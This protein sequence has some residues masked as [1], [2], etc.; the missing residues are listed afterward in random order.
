MSSIATGLLA[1]GC[2]FGAGLLGMLLQAV[3]PKH[4]LSP[5]TKDLVRL[6]MGLVSTMTALVLGLLVAS[7]KGAYDAQRTGVSEMAAKVAFLDRLLA[8]YGTETTEARA[9]LRDAVGVALARVWPEKK[10]GTPHLIP[11]TS[12]GPALHEAIQKLSPQSEAQ[13]SLKSQAVATAME[14]ARMQ[15]LLFEQT[16]TSISTIL[17]AIVIL[18]LALLFLSFGMFA[19]TNTTAIATL[20]VAAFS[21]SA[22]LFLVLE[23]DRPFRGL[24]EISNEPIL[25]ALNYL[26]H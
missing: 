11:N 8:T 12:H 19:P 9:V 21:V 26:G 20:M 10:S 14:L 17:L 24:I 15:W 3:L 5:D 7:A 4:H 18:W 6:A 1:F 2:V 22:A 25:K 16:G 13:R 23:L